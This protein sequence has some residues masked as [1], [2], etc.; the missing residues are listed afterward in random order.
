[1]ARDVASI[2]YPATR[3]NIPTAGLAAQGEVREKAAVRYEYNPHL[4]PA[5]RSAPDA[6][7]T[8]RLPELPEAARRRARR[9]AM[10]AKLG[11]PAKRRAAPRIDNA[12]GA[13]YTA[14]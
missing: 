12:R 13:V 3:R 7:A 4:P 11:A 6:T 9:P 8:D 1:M 5:L 2:T 14:T 10:R